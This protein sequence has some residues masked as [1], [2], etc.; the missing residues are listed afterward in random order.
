M[1]GYAK[2]PSEPKW[3]WSKA[4]RAEHEAQAAQAQAEKRAQAEQKREQKARDAKA[5]ALKLRRQL[6]RAGAHRVVQTNQDRF[7]VEQINAQGKWF[8]VTYY[9]EWLNGHWE[10]LKT[11]H[12]ESLEQA[13]KNGQGFEEDFKS[14]VTWEIK[15]LTEYSN[16]LS[17]PNYEP[18]PV[19]G[20]INPDEALVRAVAS[21][22]GGKEYKYT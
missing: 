2:K 1:G 19:N 13:A 18:I 16:I 8:P 10:D 17:P 20:G 9:G 11:H 3:W 14:Q 12:Y 15:R 22:W 7:H 4:R 21:V 6:R 5:Q